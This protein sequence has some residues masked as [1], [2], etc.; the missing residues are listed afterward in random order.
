MYTIITL[1]ME[2]KDHQVPDSFQKLYVG[3]N[4]KE[5][6]ITNRLRYN[7]SKGCAKINNL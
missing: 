3:L 1:R 4:C 6:V 2:H 7:L 5:G